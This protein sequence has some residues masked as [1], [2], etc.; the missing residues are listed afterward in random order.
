MNT[1]RSGVH[2]QCWSAA[3]H[4]AVN[5]FVRV[6]D[7][8]LHCHFDRLAY[9]HR[10]RTG[11]DI[12]VKG[13]ILRQPNVHISRSGAHIPGAGLGALSSNVSAAGFAMEA[14]LDAACA[15]IARPGMQVDI[16]RSGLFNLHIA[17][18]GSTFH[19]AR[20]VVRPN[21][22]GASLQPDFPIQA[23]ELHIARSS[24]DVHVAMRA[25]NDLVTRAAAGAN[26]GIG[27]NRDLVI[28]GNIA[29]I[30]IIDVDAI[31][32]LAKW[33][34]LFNGMH[35]L[36]ATSAEPAIAHKDLAANEYP[37][38]GSRAPRD[39]AG[40][41]EHFQVDGTRDLPRLF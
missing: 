18:A 28:D 35:V 29:V 13:G 6:S 12:G 23:A 7:S 14:A 37:S 2:P 1:A 17:A 9:I 3:V 31:A 10:A 26:G 38:G 11:G 25:L 41:R 22:P 40:M 32:A 20:D 16:S 8:P 34:V 19:R 33:R 39:L 27:R 24:L 4:F 36:F 15:E 5:G 21:V 30:H